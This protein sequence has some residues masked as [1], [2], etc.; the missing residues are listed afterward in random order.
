MRIS[1]IGRRPICGWTNG[2]RSAISSRQ[3]SKRRDINP[4]YAVS[5]LGERHT[6][7]LGV[8]N[9]LFGSDTQP[10]DQYEN[11]IGL[12]IRRGCEPWDCRCLDTN[13]PGQ[14]CPAETSLDTCLIYRA[15]E[16]AKVERS[17]P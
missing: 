11:T 16:L 4:S 17:L 6:R 2:A 8:G 13:F 15:T 9:K 3:F 5:G 12:C 1:W 7:D 10:A 14:L